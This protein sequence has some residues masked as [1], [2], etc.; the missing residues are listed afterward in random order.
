MVA[1]VVIGNN[2]I[3]YNALST[4]DRDVTL[5]LLVVAVNDYVSC[6]A[7]YAPRKPP[8]KIE[9]RKEPGLT[10]KIIGGSR[11]L[12]ASEMLPIRQPVIAFETLFADIRWNRKNGHILDAG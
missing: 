4:T 2:C 12:C 6:A 1:R 11:L 7:Q 5:Y 3:G 10:M 8:S 9:N